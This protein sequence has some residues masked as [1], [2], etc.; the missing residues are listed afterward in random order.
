MKIE[1]ESFPI[2]FK[3]ILLKLPQILFIILIFAFG[4]VIAFLVK[5]F[6]SKG[7]SLIGFNKLC[8]KVGISEFLRKGLI[9]Y[10]PSHIMGLT[11]FWLIFIL[12]LF[13]VADIARIAILGPLFI[14]IGES[15]P[16]FFT[17]IA[18]F[19]V[20]YVIVSFFSNFIF[21]IASNAAFPHTRLLSRGIKIV[22]LLFIIIIAVD[23]L[24]INSRII[25]QT[26]LIIIAAFSFG[27]ALAFGLAAKDIAKDI[28]EKIRRN[29]SDRDNNRGDMEG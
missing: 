23:N 13:I 3:E 14:R 5:F 18:L 22:G 29:L 15:I 4:I 24:Q 11:G 6:L 1:L 8:D 28:L 10:T 17:A 27:V 19:I 26:F 7:L 2:L 21:T 20:G 16:K 12:T 9:S 25:T